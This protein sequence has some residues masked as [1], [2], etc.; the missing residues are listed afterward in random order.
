MLDF[1]QD[2][3]LVCRTLPGVQQVFSVSVP[4]VQ[5][6]VLAFLARIFPMGSALCFP[7][8]L[9]LT[10]T[11]RPRSHGALH[12]WLLDSAPSSLWAICS[13][14]GLVFIQFA[15]IQM[16]VM[17]VWAMGVLCKST[18]AKTN[19]E[20]NFPAS[21]NP[22]SLLVPGAEMPVLPLTNM[23]VRLA[24]FT[25]HFSCAWWPPSVS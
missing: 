14:L 12:L 3:K 20:P 21:P 9:N 8:F 18:N 2:R 5:R 16:I 15:D 24:P 22:S 17:N 10:P 23:D 25:L 4:M 6:A 19:Q 7:F 11:D 1:F 13:K